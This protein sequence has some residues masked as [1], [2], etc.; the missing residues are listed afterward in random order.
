MR[1]ATRLLLKY[2]N[3]EICLFFWQFP[4]N[5]QYV[6]GGIRENRQ[7]V[8]L[9][10][11]GVGNIS[12]SD[13]KTNRQTN[14]HTQKTQ[15]D[16]PIGRLTNRQTNRKEY[17]M[18]K[19]PNLSIFSFFSSTICVTPRD[20]PTPFWKIFIIFLPTVLHSNLTVFMWVF[21]PWDFL[22]HIYIV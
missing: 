5:N 20:V 6:G 22:C 15:T 1:T 4:G 19:P 17:K 8:L 18:Y 11:N 9:C 16:R 21:L 2:I 3:L 7:R 13:R 10:S 14:K 12:H